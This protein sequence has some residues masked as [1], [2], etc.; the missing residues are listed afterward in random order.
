MTHDDNTDLDEWLAPP[1]G[2]PDT[3]ALQRRLLE[4]YDAAMRAKRAGPLNALADAFGW[5]ALARPFAPAALGAAMV[6]L[7]AVFGATTSGSFGA[8]AR[9]DEAYAYLSAA[10]DPSYGFSEEVSAWAGQ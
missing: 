10:L 2:V 7:G 6:A 1:R 9:D 3:A 5:R 8:G 4:D